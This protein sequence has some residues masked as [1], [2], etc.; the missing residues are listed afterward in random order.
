MNR[1]FQLLSMFAGI[2]VAGTVAGQSYPNKPIRVLVGY[3]AG[4][5]IDVNARLVGAQMEKRL[6]QPFLIENRP[7]AEGTIAAN[8]V[9]SAAPDGYTLMF[10]GGS[11]IHPMFA[12]SGGVVVGKDLAPISAVLSGG[13]FGMVRADLPVQSLQDLIAYSKANPGRLNSGTTSANSDLVMQVL[14]A[15]TGLSYT[16]VPYKGVAPVTTA[17]LAGEV[18]ITTTSIPTFLPHIR[19]GK[20][21]VL[22]STGPTTIV[23]NVPTLAQLGIPNFE[24]ANFYLGYWAPVGTPKDIVQKLSSDATVVARLPQIAEQFRAGGSEPLGTTPEEQLRLAEEEH[25]FWGEALR[26]T[27]TQK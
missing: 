25:R 12:P 5:I 26:L 18:D 21:R 23:T 16:S 11:G 2:A 7:G 15:R 10:G 27:R 8:A 17:M 3:T 4:G 24:G 19:S 20:I 1:T 9:V 13:W 6:G 22:F 14:K